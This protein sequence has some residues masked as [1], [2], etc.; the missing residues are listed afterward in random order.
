MRFSRLV[1]SAVLVLAQLG[2]A[3]AQD[4]PTRFITL[5]VPFGAGNSVDIFGRLMATRMSEVLGQQIVVENVGGAGGATGTLRA[6]RSAPDGYTIV[7]G[8]ADTIALVFY[9]Q[10]PI[11]RNTYTA[12]MNIDPAL[13]D[14]WRARTGTELHEAMGMSECS[15]FLSGSPA[16]PARASRTRRS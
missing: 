13:R 6:A 1:L 5:I 11:I 15:T 10:L 8:G 9:A 12:I 16:R 3:A 14:A 4:W 2:A 7:V